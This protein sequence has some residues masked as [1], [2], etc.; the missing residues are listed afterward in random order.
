[1]IYT[2]CPRS[3]QDGKAKQAKAKELAAATALKKKKKVAASDDFGFT[4]DANK[5]KG[6]KTTDDGFAVY[7]NVELRI[8]EGR[9]ETENCPFDCECCY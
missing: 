1:M 5:G 8:G 7:D 9:G 2:Y 4:R 6:R 3:T